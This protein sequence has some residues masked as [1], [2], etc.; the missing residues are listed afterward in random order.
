MSPFGWVSESAQSRLL[1]VL[2]VLTV[3]VSARL[4]AAGAVLETLAA[5][6]GI[7]SY[8]F[9]WSAAGA[10]AVLDSW[11]ANAKAA[12]M[13]VQGLDGLFL[14]LY[15]ACLSLA[16]LRLGACLGGGWARA[17]LWLSWA[18]LLAA[19]FD[20]V[21]NHGL[22]RQLISGPSALWAR[23]S[24]L[25]AIPKFALVGLGAGFLVVGALVGLGRRL[26]R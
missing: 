9:A 12:A 18:V 15:P 4:G 16:V 3:G 21:E 20:A 10:A 14:L 17:G 25:C 23:V 1:L 11:D 2:I 22:V 13:F 24:A 7:I 19:P 5:P 26:R 6:R 8:E